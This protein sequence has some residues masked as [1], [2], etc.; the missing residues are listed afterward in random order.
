MLT[1]ILADVHYS[2]TADDISICPAN[3]IDKETSLEEFNRVFNNSNKGEASVFECIANIKSVAD[4]RP[5]YKFNQI[6]SRTIEPLSFCI[7]FYTWLN[8][9]VVDPLENVIT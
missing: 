8:S 4:E 1:A 7:V 5:Y 9:W 3:E 2:E 6:W